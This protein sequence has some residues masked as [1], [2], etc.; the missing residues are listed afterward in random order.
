MTSTNKKPVEIRDE[1]LKCVQCTEKFKGED[2]T[3]RVLQCLHMV[4]SPC[5]TTL[6]KG[7]RAKCPECQHKIEKSEKDIPI[8]YTKEDLLDF[9]RSFRDATEKKCYMCDKKADIRCY[10]CK[11][12]YCNECSCKIHTNLKTHKIFRLPDVTRP[13]EFTYMMTCPEEGHGIYPLQYYCETCKMSLCS[14]CRVKEHL[15]KEHHDIKDLSSKFEETTKI[16]TDKKDSMIDTLYDIKDLQGNIVQVQKHLRRESAAAERQVTFYFNMCIQLLEKRKQSLLHE[17]D[18]KY[19]EN[20]KILIDQG[21]ELDKVKRKI[22]HSVKFLDHSILSQNKVGFLKVASF[23]DERFQE[24]AKFKYDRVPRVKGDIEFSTKNQALFP[25]EKFM[26][27]IPVHGVISSPMVFHP[28]CEITTIPVECKDDEKKIKVCLNDHLGEIVVDD[29]MTI[30]GVFKDKITRKEHK[31]AFVRDKPGVY[32]SV[33]VVKNA[34][35][36]DINIMINGNFLEN[37]RGNFFVKCLF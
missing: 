15:K 1:F 5:L 33:Q 13:D 8:D 17:I 24:M 32:T 28:K 35:D 16:L 6:I 3:P 7:K 14:E 4:C 20:W 30:A 26:D 23:I 21:A 29:T 36:L 37:F 18:E 34:E 10:D 31:S 12:F 22:T 25:T 27:M 19:K 2:K 9:E 11:L